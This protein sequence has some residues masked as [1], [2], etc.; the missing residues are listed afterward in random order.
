MLP[1]LVKNKLK[2]NNYSLIIKIYSYNSKMAVESEKEFESE[3]QKES[4]CIKR[5]PTVSGFSAKIFPISIIIIRWQFA[6]LIG[7]L[8]NASDG[9]YI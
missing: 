2:L 4:V 7:W 6:F 8:V 5:K 9:R 1:P 3:L